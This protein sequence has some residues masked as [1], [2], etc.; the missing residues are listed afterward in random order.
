MCVSGGEGDSGDR[1]LGQ[2]M[3]SSTFDSTGSEA[4]LE[5][6]GSAFLRMGVFASVKA[7]RECG[8]SYLTRTAQAENNRK[9][10]GYVAGEEGRGWWEVS[11]PRDSRCPKPP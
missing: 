3:A 7:P 11:Q 6:G 4:R 9:W 1:K 2:S 5:A 10:G 8:S